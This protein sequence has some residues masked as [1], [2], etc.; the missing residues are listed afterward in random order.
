MLAIMPKKVKL[1]SKM[2]HKAHF[3]KEIGAFKKSEAFNRP[4]IC[5]CKIIERG[6]LV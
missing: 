4:D 5:T 6:G 1:L 3:G 2:G